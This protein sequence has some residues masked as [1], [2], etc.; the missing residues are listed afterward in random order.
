[1]GDSAIKGASMDFEA[2]RAAMPVEGVRARKAQLRADRDSIDQELALLDLLEQTYTLHVHT[3]DT[4]PHR[5]EPESHSQPVSVNGNGNGNG[6]DGERFSPRIVELPQRKR[7]L[8][9]E[10]AAII[11]LIEQN[12]QGMSP[13][14]VWRRLT[15]DGDATVKQNAVQTTMGRMVQAGQLLRVEQ[16]RYRLPSQVPGGTLLSAAAAV[17]GGGD[18]EDN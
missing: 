6:H 16:G 8:S 1:M 5:P 3:E 11:R 10:R 2:W 13:T 14:D 15:A 18:P 7:R 9:P 12:P 4:E 17:L